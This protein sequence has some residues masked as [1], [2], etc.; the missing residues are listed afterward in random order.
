[1]KAT[2]VKDSSGLWLVEEDRG[3]LK[4]SYKLKEVLFHTTTPFQE[5]LI[6]DSF[7]FK[8]MLVLD[9]VVQTTEVDGYIYNEMLAHI[10]LV[11]HE[12]PKKALVIGG[13]DCGVAYELTKYK[14]LESIH[15]VEID[16]KVVIA[17]KEYLT[18]VCFNVDDSRISFIYEDGRDYIQKLKKYFDIVIVDSSDPVG[19]ALSLFTKDFYKGVYESLKED[20]LMVCQSQSPIFHLDFLK[21][22]LSFLQDIFPKV[23]LYTAT[24]PTYPGGFWSFALGTK[25]YTKIHKEKLS[26]STRYLN[27]DILESCFS[28]PFFLQ[29]SLTE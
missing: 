18:E 29:K 24:V 11:I 12:N 3:K 8:R 16:E 5:V 23:K 28:L 15:L 2:L 17:S 22:L 26:L 27:K 10:P 1:M 13:G 9:G 6:V 7:D 20:G 4:I 25:K 19:P 14:S 21:S